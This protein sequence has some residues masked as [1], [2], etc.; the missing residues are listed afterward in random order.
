[1]IAQNRG[2]VSEAGCGP[3][4]LLMCGWMRKR[5][6]PHVGACS[7]KFGAGSRRCGVCSSY[8]GARSTNSGADSRALGAGLTASGRGRIQP[9]SLNEDAHERAEMRMLGHTR[10]VRLPRHEG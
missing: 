9:N 7:T 1:M 6:R 3:E 8:A 10:Q 4:M 2:R 5:A